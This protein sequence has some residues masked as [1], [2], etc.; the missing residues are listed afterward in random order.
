MSLPWQDK[1]GGLTVK[2][3]S[4]LRPMLRGCIRQ[5]WNALRTRHASMFSS[6]LTG[7]MA[8]SV[9]GDVKDAAHMAESPL[10]PVAKGPKSTLPPQ[11]LINCLPNNIFIHVSRPSCAQALLT[12]NAGLAG[13]SGAAK[14][15]PKAALALLD[16]L[17]KRLTELG[18]R[19]VRVNFRGL[20]KARPV[21][22]GQ[23]RRMGLSITEVVDSTGVPFNGCRP[24]KAR[25]L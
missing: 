16:I 13:F 23:L 19:Q 1:L 4:L 15:S 2:H 7:G 14:T 21:I 10:K 18:V 22:V 5:T 9:S 3:F 11:V 24:P 25:R 12:L 8:G 17:Q 20:N 6:G